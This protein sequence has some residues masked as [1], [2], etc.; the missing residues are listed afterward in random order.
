MSESKR[1]IRTAF[2]NAVLERAGDRCEGCGATGV[3]LDAHHIIDRR[4]MPHGGYVPSNGIALC[5][6]GLGCHYRAER[7][8]NDD[9]EF[10]QAALFLRIGSSERQARADAARLCRGGQALKQRGTSQR[11]R[12]RRAEVEGRQWELCHTTACA[13]CWVLE[14]R[15][16]GLPIDWSQLPMLDAG[17]P[18]SEGHHEPDRSLGGK[19]A[20]CLPLGPSKIKGGCGHHDQRTKLGAAAFWGWQ[21]IKATGEWERVGSVLGSVLDINPGE[22]IGEMRRRAA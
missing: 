16:L 3:T 4:L 9:P 2:R 20:D 8:A 21:R 7:A 15:H 1:A 11:A 13:A 14:Q 17:E 22:P 5:D 6:V 18:R 19:D 12:E 10:G